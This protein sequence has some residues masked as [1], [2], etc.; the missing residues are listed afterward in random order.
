MLTNFSILI[1]K[2]LKFANP[3]DSLALD[4][5]DSKAGGQWRG[6]EDFCT[7]PEGAIPLNRAAYR[8]FWKIA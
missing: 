1:S 5:R 6:S 7:F 2:F 4:H 8:C 3:V